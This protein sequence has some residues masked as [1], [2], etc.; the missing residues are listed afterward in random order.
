[1]KKVIGTPLSADLNICSAT[2]TRKKFSGDGFGSENLLE[3]HFSPFIEASLTEI[4]RRLR[5]GWLFSCARVWGDLTDI[6]KVAAAEGSDRDKLIVFLI[7]D[8]F[9]QFSQ[10]L[11]LLEYLFVQGEYRHLSVHELV[12]YLQK[13]RNGYLGDFGRAYRFD[14]SDSA[15]NAG[16]GSGYHGDC[17]SVHESS[18]FSERGE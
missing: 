16:N 12:A 5:S 15:V 9:A 18:F 4:T 17:S 2:A 11:C 7:R 6:S 10:F 14:Y 13:C 3:S 1:M 8:N